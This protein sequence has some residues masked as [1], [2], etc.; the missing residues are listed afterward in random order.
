MHGVIIENLED[1]H[2][3]QD[4]VLTAYHIVTLLFEK[5]AFTKMLWAD[6]GRSWMKGLGPVAQPSAQ[7]VAVQAAA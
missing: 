2:R 7:Q 1:D 5:T 4:D 6:T 3:L